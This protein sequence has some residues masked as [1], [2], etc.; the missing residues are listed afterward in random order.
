M[1]RIVTL[2]AL[3]MQIPP[4]GPRAPKPGSPVELSAKLHVR[5]RNY[6][7]KAGNFGDALLRVAGELRIPMGIEWVETTPALRDVNFFWADATVE[8]VIKDIVKSQP[9]Y[10]TETKNGVLHVFAPALVADRESFLKVKVPEFDVRGEV[11]EIAERRLGQI[12]TANVLPPQPP[13]KPAAGRKAVG[14]TAFTQGAEVG[15][16]ILTL[17]LRDATVENVLDA[18]SLA[19][20]KSVWVVSFADAGEL[21]PTGFRRTLSPLG[22]QAGPHAAKPYWELLQ[23]GRSPY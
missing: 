9:G 5:A 11:V 16:P 6:A 19:S 15:D 10:Q 13:P 3:M 20:G 23:W 4:T 22:N 12:V 7:L 17:T 18:L 2:C 21:W 1:F 14:G 8:E